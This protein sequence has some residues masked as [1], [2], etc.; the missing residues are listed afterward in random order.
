MK[1]QS[2]S[3][4]PFKNYIRIHLQDKSRS[5]LVVNQTPMDKIFSIASAN[6]TPLF[7]AKDVFI[8]DSSD[9]IKED[10][11]KSNIEYQE[12]EESNERKN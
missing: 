6:E 4:I 2:P 8:L 12:V 3:T 7:I 11:Q 5:S 9:K 1:I 10:L